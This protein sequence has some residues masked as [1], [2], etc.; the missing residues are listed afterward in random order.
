MTALKKRLYIALIGLSFF[1]PAL[2]AKQCLLAKN[3]SDIEIDFWAFFRPEQFYGERFTFL[4]NNVPEDKTFYFRHTLDYFVNVLYGKQTFGYPTAEFKTSVRNRAV[5]GSPAGIATTLPADSPLLNADVKN[6]HH[7]L[8]R[9]FFW[10]R[11]GWV[12]FSLSPFLHLGFENE[13]SFTL[14]AFPF[15]L[16]RGIAL[17]AAYAIGPGPLGFYSDSMIDQFAFGF[18]FSG[19]ITP[20]VLTY[21][22]Y[23]ALLQAKSATLAETNKPIYRNEIGRRDNPQRGFGKDNYLVAARLIWNAFKNDAWGLLAVEPYIMFNN[24]PEQRVEFPAD[25]SSKLG[26]FG[27]AAEYVGN[28]F[29]C[30]FDFAQNM[31]NQFVRPWDRNEIVFENINGAI[32]LVN[33]QVI[34]VS[35]NA[36]NGV[37]APDGPQSVGQKAINKSEQ[38]GSSVQ[39]GQLIEGAQNLPSLGVIPGPLSLQNSNRRFRT[40]PDGNGYKNIYRGY[41]IVGDALYWVCKNEFQVALTVGLASGDQDPNFQVKDGT[42]DGFIGLQEVYAGKRVKSVFLLGT[43][44]KVKRPG[45]APENPLANKDFA[46]TA[47]GFTNLGFVGAGCT[48]KPAS[49]GDVRLI[50][51]PNIFA[52]WED[53]P[54]NKFDAFTGTNLPTRASSFLGVELNS[55]LSYYPFASLKCF[56]I[57]SV[58]F[59]G[60]HF[61]DIKGKPLDKGQKKLLARLDR[62]G[63]NPDLIPNIGDNTAYTI[64][65]GLEF[66]F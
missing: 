8:P 4:N 10:M 34:V 59:P 47:S 50:W 46:V 32:N 28:K 55:F 39:N 41:M 51:N 30:G 54:G 16:G 25:A 36:F 62:Q 5:W 14:G 18:K 23:G 27:I 42:Y 64:N 57:G 22:L 17:G 29:E 35:D 61:T 21:D 58:F 49:C 3:E 43:V 37:Q 66:T 2:F 52:Y 20:Q 38:S 7:A 31:G 44:G 24:D 65:I 63:L 15:E 13:H 33:S 60:K 45:A 19:T 11:E 6:H 56:A 1:S 12:R 48:W 26:T 9:L 53:S 40:G